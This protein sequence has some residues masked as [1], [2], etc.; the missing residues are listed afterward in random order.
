MSVSQ[1]GATTVIR[2]A[3][4]LVAWDG[5]QHVYLRDA[6]IAFDGADITFVGHGYAGTAAV[7]IDGRDRL[8]MPGFVNIHS[9]PTAEPM[10][11]G[12]TEERKSRKLGMSTMYEYLQV[13][14][15]SNRTLTLADAAKSADPH[16]YEDREARSASARFGI[17][18]MLRSGVTTVTDYSPNRSNW[19]QE[20][21]ATGIRA[22]IAPSF[23]SGRFYTVNGHEVIYEWN[24]AAGRQAFDE[25]M[26]V[27]D[28]VA[29]DG[30]GR[31]FGMVA[32]GQIDTCTPELLI[33]AKAAARERDLPMQLHA[34]QSMMEFREMTRRHGKTPI[35]WLESLGLLDDKFIVGHGIFLDQH[36]WINW[37]DRGDLDRLASSGA[38]VAHCPAQFCRGGVTMEN[39]GLYRRAGVNIGFGTDT[40]PHNF[41]D[42][43][44]W[45]MILAKVAA[46]DVDATSVNE[47]FH[48]GTIGGAHALHRND[49]GRLAPGCK[50]DIVLVD[51]THPYMQP[52]RDPLRNLLFSALER[53]I[54]DV[55]VDGRQ[56]VRDGE[57]VTIDVASLRETLNA[58]QQ[59]AL[60]GVPE[61]DWAGRDADEMFPPVLPINSSY[62]APRM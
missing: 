23:R 37:P 10:L 32:P 55:Y 3:A 27:L 45:G 22:C 56:V 21:L 29:K 62:S 17:A 26:G 30:S 47:I 5:K 6:D 44:R 46:R 38:S 24:E 8:V 28:E 60:L 19:L 40:A 43:M 50:A 35:E 39:F 48:A 57:V 53:P 31:L 36:S 33:D 15:R 58:A 11:R 1:A 54:S 18:E 2:N 9:H 61:R 49:I 25:A 41:I 13:I 14:G 59:R 42:E 12:L 52:L 4:W 16:I 34:A 51:T 20:V 7:E